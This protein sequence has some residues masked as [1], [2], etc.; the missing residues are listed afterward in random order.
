MLLCLL[1]RFL[2]GSLR[3]FPLL[4][5]DLLQLSLNRRPAFRCI[6][7][8]PCGRRFPPGGRRGLT[9][10]GNP[11]FC[12]VLRLLFLSAGIRFQCL[13]KK[14]FHLFLMRQS[15]V[16]RL[17]FFTLC[18]FSPVLF[19][20]SSH[21]SHVHRCKLKSFK[22]PVDLTCVLCPNHNVC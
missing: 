2:A 15:T 11:A 10:P 13:I 5:S 18:S 19:D 16:G 12:G 6:R 1:T 20:L 22:D 21:G 17:Y 3:R 14:S 4:T 7:S 9:G 8:V